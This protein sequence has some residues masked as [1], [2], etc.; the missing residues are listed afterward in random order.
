[1][2][3]RPITWDGEPSGLAVVRDISRQ[4]AAE[5]A[6]AESEARYKHLLDIS[7]DAIY[8]HREGRIVLINEAGAKLFGADSAEAMLGMQTIDLVHPDSREE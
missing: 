3:V 8:V 6:R 5:Q 2:T 1:M 4:K 7:P